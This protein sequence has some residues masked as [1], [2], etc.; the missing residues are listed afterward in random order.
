MKDDLFFLIEYHKR[1]ISLLSPFMILIL[2]VVFMAQYTY[3]K[4]NDSDLILVL[5]NGVVAIFTIFTLFCLGVDW[6]NLKL[7]NKMAISISYFLTV[8]Y[9]IVIIT[10]AMLAIINSTNMIKIG[11]D[12]GIIK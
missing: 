6:F 12:I 3:I 4:Y 7:K 8:I 9:L 2:S 1:V 11:F 10:V 5:M